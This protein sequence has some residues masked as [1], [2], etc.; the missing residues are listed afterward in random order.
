MKESLDKENIVCLIEDKEVYRLVR[1]NPGKVLQTNVEKY[2]NKLTKY[3]FINHIEKNKLMNTCMDPR[4]KGINKLISKIHIKV[5]DGIQTPTYKLTKYFN[6][7]SDN[8][9]MNNDYDVRVEG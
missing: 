3:R 9:R 4:L 2:V 1:E 8:L 7:T 5:I 6:R